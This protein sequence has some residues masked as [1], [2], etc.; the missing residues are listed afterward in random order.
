MITCRAIQGNPMTFIAELNGKEVGRMETT[1]LPL[2][3]DMEIPPSLISHKVADALFH[4]AS[5]YVKAS[6]FGD[7]LMLV[8]KD[9]VRMRA[10]MQTLQEARK[11]P[12]S[13]AYMVAVK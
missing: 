7:T 1:I 6:G 3:H 8:R 5:G 10:Y 9:N 12:E 2:V 13:D 4:Y 11:E